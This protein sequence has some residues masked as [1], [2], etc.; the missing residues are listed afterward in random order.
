MVSEGGGGTLACFARAGL[1]ERRPHVVRA[2]IQCVAELVP[3]PSAAASAE[4]HYKNDSDN[5]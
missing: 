3:D 4:R 2:P 5:D 1:T